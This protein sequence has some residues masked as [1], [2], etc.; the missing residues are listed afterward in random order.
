MTHDYIKEL[1]KDL[2]LDALSEQEQKQAAALIE[3]RF[4]KAMIAATLKLLTPWQRARF[5]GALE[6][7]KTMEMAIAEISAEIPG[8]SQVLEAV[9]AREHETVRS[10]MKG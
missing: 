10:A 8:L 4:N 3:E 5:A 9:L 2:G 6:N 7:P 1:M